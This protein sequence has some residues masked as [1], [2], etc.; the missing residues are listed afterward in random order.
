MRNVIQV[1]CV[2]EFH[3]NINKYLCVLISLTFQAEVVSGIVIEDGNLDRSEIGNVV[4][5]NKKWEKKCLKG[6]RLLPPQAS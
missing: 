1:L 2:F 3:V 6:L 4:R 5:C